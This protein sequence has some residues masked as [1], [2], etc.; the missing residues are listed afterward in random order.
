MKVFISNKTQKD[1]YLCVPN[2]NTLNVVVENGEADEIIV[3]N[4]LSGFSKDRTVDILKAILAK[5]KLNGKIVIFQNDIEILSWQLTRGFINIDDFN[6]ALFLDG[7]ILSTSTIEELSGLLKDHNF[8]VTSKR[9]IGFVAAI[10]GE[11]NA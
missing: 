8:Q 11:R 5:V 6:N 7:P 10:T 4:F 2:I 3:D 1:G 9:I